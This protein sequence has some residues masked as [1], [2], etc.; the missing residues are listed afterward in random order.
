ML[1]I[2]SF[3]LSG[4]FGY[5]L[6]TIGFGFKTQEF[7]IVL[8]LYLLRSGISYTQGRIKGQNEQA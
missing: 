3:L 5:Y 7:W 2:F 1:N 6:A 8:G 4:F